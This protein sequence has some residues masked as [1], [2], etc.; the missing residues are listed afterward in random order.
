MQVIFFC[1]QKF[2]VQIQTKKHTGT[3]EVTIIHLDDTE[4]NRILR[5]DMKTPFRREHIHILRQFRSSQLTES[6]LIKLCCNRGA[7][8]FGPL[9]VSVNVRNGSTFDVKSPKTV[10]EGEQKE[11]T[12]RHIRNNSV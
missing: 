6:G 4:L 2:R 5:D 10:C 8:C 12:I 9:K 1:L 3:A 7:F 11:A